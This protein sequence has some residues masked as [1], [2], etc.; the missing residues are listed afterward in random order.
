MMLRPMMLLDPALVRSAP[1]LA[2]LETLALV[3]Q[4]ALV[5]LTAAHPCLERDGPPCGALAPCHLARAIHDGIDELDN[6][7][8]Y[9]RAVV[10][11]VLNDEQNGQLPF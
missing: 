6:A 4:T 8:N 5:T 2:T 10:E 1:E 11:D 7:I 3:L 9:Y